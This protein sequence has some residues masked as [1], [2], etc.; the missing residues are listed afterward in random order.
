MTFEY[1]QLRSAIFV[2][3]QQCVYLDMDDADKEAT[4]ILG[5]SESGKVV[6]GTRVLNGESATQCHIGRVVVA[7]SHR[8]SGLGKAIMEAS[9][10]WCKEHFGDTL[11]KGLSQEQHH[12]GHLIRRTVENHLYF[13]HVYSRFQDDD[14]W[15]YQKE[16][17]KG[18][19]PA[20]LRPILTGV[21]RKSVTKSLHGHGLARHDKAIVYRHAA[22]D[23]QAIAGMLGDKDFIVGDT[24]TSYDCAL[25]PVLDGIETT[26]SDNAL[27]AAYKSHDA[28]V[29]YHRRMDDKLGWS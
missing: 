28:L 16:V 12:L 27:K 2:V 13:A 5:L 15:A 7:K 4:H 26:P 1:F 23:L 8:G 25:W 10:V 18:I 29:A 3:E 22:E 9:H 17:V 6:A 24:P 20:V 21:I 19:L 14:G 11:D